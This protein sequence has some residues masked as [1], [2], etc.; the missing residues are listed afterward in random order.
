MV[1]AIRKTSNVSRKRDGTEITVLREISQILKDKDH[2]SFL[3]C[4]IG[5][6]CES[7]TRVVEEEGGMGRAEGGEYDRRIDTHGCNYY[8]THCFVQ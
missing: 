8:K 7:S 4:G 5:K 3:I 2:V 1:S 6:G